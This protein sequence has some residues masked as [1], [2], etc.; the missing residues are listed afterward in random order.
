MYGSVYLSPFLPGEWI[1][2]LDSSGAEDW[3]GW[4]EKGAYRVW[5]LFILLGHDGSEPYIYHVCRSRFYQRGIFL[6][7]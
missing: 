7:L 1:D 3:R 6:Q 2:F 5:M 4:A